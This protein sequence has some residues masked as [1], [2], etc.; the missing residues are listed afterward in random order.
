MIDE[1]QPAVL[2]RK[3]RLPDPSKA[4]EGVWKLLKRTRQ[5]FDTTQ[6][7]VSTV[8]GKS[9]ETFRAKKHAMIEAERQKA[10]G[11]GYSLRSSI[12]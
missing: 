11:V 2:E 9:A 3:L 8:S 6:S 1:L 12:R 4:I 5:Q 7:T 10:R